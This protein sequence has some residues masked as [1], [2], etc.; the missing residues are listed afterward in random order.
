[1][2]VPRWLW[3][4]HYPRL[5]KALEALSTDVGVSKQLKSG[6]LPESSYNRRI[7]L[8]GALTQGGTIILAK[9]RS[10]VESALFFKGLGLEGFVQTWWL[11]FGFLGHCFH[12]PRLDQHRL[13]VIE[14][15]YNLYN[16]CSF[17][18]IFHYPNITPKYA[19]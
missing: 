9:Y 1:M 7:V 5:S 10:S 2:R 17:H 13:A 8:L 11:G 14:S 19:L 18:F 3:R 12:S 15:L 16:P 4:R 6:I